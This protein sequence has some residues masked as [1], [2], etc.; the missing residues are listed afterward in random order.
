MVHGRFGPRAPDGWVELYAKE[1]AT[2]PVSALIRA[3]PECIEP[4]PRSTP[5][6]PRH[7]MRGPSLS[8]EEFER[9]W[10][11]NESR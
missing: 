3:C 10:G 2:A 8:A 1:G 9:K 4:E 11:K 6:H 7:F 5:I